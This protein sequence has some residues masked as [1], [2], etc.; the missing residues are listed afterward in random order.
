METGMIH[1]Q[2]VAEPDRVIVRKTRSRF[3]DMTVWTKPINSELWGRN[4]AGLGD[5]PAREKETGETA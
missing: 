1:P 2:D 3:Y 4:E 5:V